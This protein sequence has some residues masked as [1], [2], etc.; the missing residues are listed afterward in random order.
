M[1]RQTDPT[2][3]SEDTGAADPGADP[4]ADPAADVVEQALDEVRRD[5][6]ARRASG[7][8]PRLPRN[9]LSSQFAGVVEASSATLT[10]R[11]HVDVPGL[12]AAALLPSWRP[13]RGNPLKW[14]LGTL[15]RP[16]YAL[17][18]PFVRRQVRDFA[19]RTFRAVR[20]LDDRQ[21]TMAEFMAGA[22]LDRI[23]TLEHRV[24][25]LEEEL[26]RLR[27]RED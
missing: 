5:L 8:L 2:T 9:A 14:L 3:V 1:T 23:R 27:D 16:L 10:R 7:E 21:Q 12:G 24:A 11:S 13:V 18:G 20:E 6:A 17:T 15:L 22:H 19:D 26:D 4:A 25:E